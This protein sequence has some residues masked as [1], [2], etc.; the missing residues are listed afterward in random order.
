MLDLWKAW[1]KLPGFIFGGIR[2]KK[3]TPVK[4]NLKWGMGSC[5]KESLKINTSVTYHINVFFHLFTA[6]QLPINHHDIYEG[7]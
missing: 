6:I 1:Y 3:E 2:K 7:L 5:V 4:V